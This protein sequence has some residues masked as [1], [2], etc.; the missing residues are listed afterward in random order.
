[1]ADLISLGHVQRPGTFLN[2]PGA[3]LSA[4]KIDPGRKRRPSFGEVGPIPGEY[5][6]VVGFVRSEGSLSAPD[7]SP[8]AIPSIT[9][10]DQVRDYA[11]AGFSSANVRRVNATV[12]STADSWRLVTDFY[13]WPYDLAT[14][15]IPRSPSAAEMPAL[16]ANLRGALL[17][18]DSQGR[19]MDST[20]SV[21]GGSTLDL[22]T[23]V[24]RVQRELN[25]TGYRDN[26]GRQLVLDGDWGERSVQAFTRAKQAIPA[27]AALTNSAGDLDRAGNILAA[28]PAGGSATPSPPIPGPIPSPIPT[29]PI[30]PPPIQRD[31][32][33]MG[34][35]PIALIGVGAWLIWSAWK[36]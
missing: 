19:L 30:P 9:L 35:G 22:V 1:M 10:I 16:L 5:T 34:I 17:Y 15:A 4:P 26:A 7:R 27:L 3:R 31:E 20:W 11:R 24:T 13:R 2:Y 21:V 12:A 36:S 29:P 33:G 28:R 18:A 25:R 23:I 14:W 6:S 32:A 8:V